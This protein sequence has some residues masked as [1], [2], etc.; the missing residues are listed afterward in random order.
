MLDVNTLPNQTE[1]DRAIILGALN[2]IIWSVISRGT[3]ALDADDMDDLHSRAVEAAN[4]AV[5]D[6]R[7]DG[8][9]SLA[10]LVVR[11]VIQARRD[12]VRRHVPGMRS[13]GRNHQSV[14]ENSA[15]SLECAESVECGEGNDDGTGSAAVQ[16]LEITIDM[17]RNDGVLDDRAYRILGLWRRG[18]LQREIG[19]REGICPQRVHQIIGDAV[20]K[21]RKQYRT[22]E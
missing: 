21:I 15:S 6:Y 20:R 4:R 22:A 1:A 2:G 11:Y 13:D 19:E 9:A 17:A 8:G 10:T 7:P 3:E 5:C 16:A 14:F 12:Y 18:W